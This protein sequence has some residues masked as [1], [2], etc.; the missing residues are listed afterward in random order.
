MNEAACWLARLRGPSGAHL[1]DEHARWL[2]QSPRN[3]HAFD[4]VSRAFEDSAVL[5]RSTRYS[6]DSRRKEERRRRTAFA[7]GAVAAVIAL[8]AVSWALAP[9]LIDPSPSK[10]AAKQLALSTATGEIRRFVLPDGSTAVLDTASRLEVGYEGRDIRL[11]AGRARLALADTT[12]SRTIEA[13]PA[14]IVADGATLD[15]ALGGRG[16]VA[17]AV[18]EGSALIRPRAGLGAISSFRVG[19]GQWLTFLAGQPLRTVSASKRVDAD[20]PSGWVEYRSVALGDLVAAANRY[21]HP[22][23]VIDDP[24]A[25]ALRLSGRFH[26]ADP[27]GLANRTGQLF[28]LAVVREADGIHLRLREKNV[29]RILR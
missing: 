1:A 3:R 16:R 28:D 10:T 20:W 26:I 19:R 13:G 5:R 12:R 24:G 17:I 14:R 4:R 27:A 22:P 15:V 29:R 21:A 23:I 18:I 7:G 6:P 11:V 9:R 2:A 8:V 25:R